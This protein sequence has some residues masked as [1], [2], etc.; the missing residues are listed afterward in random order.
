VVWDYTRPRFAVLDASIE[1]T[2]WRKLAEFIPRA[3]PGLA[4]RTSATRNGHHTWLARYSADNATTRYLLHRPDSGVWPPQLLFQ[5]QPALARYKLANMHPFVFNARD[6]LRIP[7]YVSLPVRP[8]VP[9]V[10]PECVTGELPDA[11]PADKAAAAAAPLKCPLG[12]KLP[13]VLLVH[14][15]PWSR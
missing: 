3:V 2:D 13:M 12:L 4:S 11:W 8:G 6:G 10:L 14:G 15:G 5:E 1:G 7:G 9:R